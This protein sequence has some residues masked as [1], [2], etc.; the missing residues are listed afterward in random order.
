MKKSKKYGEYFTYELADT[1]NTSEEVEMVRKYG[2][3]TSMLRKI[4]M[5]KNLKKNIQQN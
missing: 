1:S 3:T 5:I 2:G 4:L